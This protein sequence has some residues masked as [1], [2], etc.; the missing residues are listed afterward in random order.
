M[1]SNTYTFMS[2]LINLAEKILNTYHLNQQYQK[3][4]LAYSTEY[5][6][7]NSEFAP[8]L[9]LDDSAHKLTLHPSTNI[10]DSFSIDDDSNHCKNNDNIMDSNIRTTSDATT[11]LIIQRYKIKSGHYPS[12]GI[13]KRHLTTGALSMEHNS[14]P[15]TSIDSSTGIA[16][17][18]RLT[19]RIGD[20]SCNISTP[21][22]IRKWKKL[23]ASKQISQIPNLSTIR[24]DQINPPQQSSALGQKIVDYPT[25]GDGDVSSVLYFTMRV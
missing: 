13:S 14:H 19:T 16:E 24:S 8:S 10:E 2:E 21:K 3:Q 15:G 18:S 22:T 4:E 20:H 12:P 9:P 17:G 11:Q 23:K 5:E 6:S 1:D 25:S 7:L